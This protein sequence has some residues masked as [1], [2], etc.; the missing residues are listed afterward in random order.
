MVRRMTLGLALL[1][2]FWTETNDCLTRENS[3]KAKMIVRSLGTDFPSDYTR[4]KVPGT[5]EELEAFRREEKK[6]AKGKKI[7]KFFPFSSYLLLCG[8]GHHQSS[9]SEN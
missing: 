3:R 1:A 6:R 4:Q 9:R 8:I 5:R 2:G 7:R